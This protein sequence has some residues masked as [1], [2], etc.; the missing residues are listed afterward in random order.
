MSET[1][2]FS[3]LAK[4]L[5][6]GIDTI[7]RTVA[8]VGDDLGI[9]A[10]RES[11][12]SIAQC[13]SV[14]DADKLIRYFEER[15]KHIAATEPS[16]VAGSYSNYG[17]FYIIQLLPELFPERVKIGYTDNLETRLREHQTAAPTA[18]YLKSWECK[19][20]WDQAVMDCITR[21]DCKLVMNEVYEGNLD[22]MIQRADELFRLMPSSNTT[23]ELSEHSP[24]RAKKSDVQSGPS[25]AH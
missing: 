20:S 10:Q 17:Y 2:R 19:R 15:D 21:K 8:K 6:V 1:V 12:S 25:P 24:L 3:D 9:V 7:R 23:V 5:G 13:L 11:H 16:A 22:L 18:R 4:K 14:R